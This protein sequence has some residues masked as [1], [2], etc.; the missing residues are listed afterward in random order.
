MLRAQECDGTAFRILYS[1]FAD[2][3]SWNASEL[4]DRL[5]VDHTSTQYYGKS[6]RI[7]GNPRLL[8]I[9]YYSQCQATACR[10]MPR[11]TVSFHSGL[12]NRT[13]AR[14]VGIQ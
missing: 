11:A 6:R 2:R 10:A 3:Q 12:S 13:E 5:E 14:L 4:P 9:T 7:A 1:S 8:T